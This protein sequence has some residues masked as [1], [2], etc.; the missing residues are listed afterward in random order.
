MD[1]RAAIIKRWEYLANTIKACGNILKDDTDMPMDHWLVMV[2]DGSFELEKLIMDTLH[3]LG[4][5][6][7]PEPIDKYPDS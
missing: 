4:C 7:P 3:I 2:T 6:L 1:D 5:Y